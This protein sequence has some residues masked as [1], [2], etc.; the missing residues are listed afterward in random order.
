[1]NSTG[2]VAATWELLTEG[3][4]KVLAVIGRGNGVTTPQEAGRVTG[5]TW[6]AAARHAR[7]LRALGLVTV[8]SLPKQVSYALS[9][10]GRACLAAGE[11]PPA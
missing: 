4:R 11:G 5:T 3:E 9:G 2:D 10:R 8:T 1:V 7:M 6:Q